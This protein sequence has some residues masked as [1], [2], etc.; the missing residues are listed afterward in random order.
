M[1]SEGLCW[2]RP[3]RP[4]RA[5]EGRRPKDHVAHE[6]ARDRHVGVRHGF[7]ARANVLG[8]TIHVIVH[9]S[10]RTP[11]GFEVNDMGV[12]PPPPYFPSGARKV[13]LPP[14]FAYPQ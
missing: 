2:G 5:S 11:E 9:H 13:L 8:Y 10:C 1:C 3:R 7:V 12:A 6:Q 14:G 4:Q